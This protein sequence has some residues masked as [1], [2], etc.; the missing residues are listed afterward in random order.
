[1][2]MKSYLASITLPYY[3]ASNRVLDQFENLSLYY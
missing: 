3:I 1:M 2:I